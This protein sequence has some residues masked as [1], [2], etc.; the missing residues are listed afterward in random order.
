ME[1]TSILS[2]ESLPIEKGDVVYFFKKVGTYSSLTYDE[3]DAYQDIM[4]RTVIGLHQRWGSDCPHVRVRLDS[5]EQS[6]WTLEYCFF[7]NETRCIQEY[8]RQMK[9]RLV[10]LQ[11]EQEM[12]E[13]FIAFLNNK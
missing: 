10:A 1:Y 8:V 9:E 3:K 5:W 13:H 11:G 2:M 7:K 4:S 12:V 6:L